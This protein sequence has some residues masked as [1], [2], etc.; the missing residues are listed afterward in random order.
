MWRRLGYDYYRVRAEIP[1]T[2]RRL[3]AADTAPSMA[4]ERQWVNEHEG[5]IGSWQDLERYPWPKRSDIDFA[6]AEAAIACV[7]AEMGVIGFSGGVLEWSSTLLGLETFAVALYDD[8][9]LVREVVDRVGRLIYDAFEIFCQMDSIF[10]IW[11]GDDMGFKTATLLSPEHLREFILPWHKKYAELAHTKGR[12]FMLHSCGHVEA[13]TADLIDDVKIDAKHSFEDTIEDVREAKRTY[14][15]RI[16][17][18]GGIDVDFLCRADENSIRRRVHETL[19]VCVPGGGYC[20]GTGNTVA[21]YI[22]V[23]NYL[24]MV[25][26][27]MRYITE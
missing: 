27:G 16:A 6:Q 3:P 26:E 23:D 18:L 10:A 20:L 8:P 7:P 4:G 25:D 2:V 11:L 22:P 17:L 19:E 13:I 1:F 5:L 24:A 14:G 12:F 15:R 21:N 9:K